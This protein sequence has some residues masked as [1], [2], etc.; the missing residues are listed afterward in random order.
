MKRQQIRLITLSL[1]GLKGMQTLKACTE[2][3]LLQ[4]RQSTSCVLF[5]PAYVMSLMCSLSLRE[6]QTIKALAKTNF[7]IS[8]VYYDIHRPR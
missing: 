7:N 1:K 6:F 4:P 5:Q 3:E 2:S 8:P